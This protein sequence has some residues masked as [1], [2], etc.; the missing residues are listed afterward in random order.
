MGEMASTASV[1][2]WSEVIQSIQAVGDNWLLT[3]Q[4]ESGHTWVELIAAGVSIAQ[5]EGRQG[6][7][8]YVM[9]A[10]D[11]VERYGEPAYPGSSRTVG[12]VCRHLRV[13]RG[14]SICTPERIDFAYLG[15]KTLCDGP[16]FDASTLEIRGELI[17]HEN[18]HL[19]QFSGYFGTLV[20]RG[21]AS[22]D[23]SRGI[24][25]RQISL[26]GV[27]ELMAQMMNVGSPLDEDYKF[28]LTRPDA[29]G[30]LVLVS[31]SASTLEAWRHLQAE[32]GDSTG[33][34]VELASLLT[35]GLFG[36]AQAYRQLSEICSA[37]PHRLVP[38]R[39]R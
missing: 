29:N 2:N 39:W 7:S 19:A 16:R 33:L 4:D 9:L 32:C 25:W 17:E 26:I 30:Q 18:V 12:A 6:D 21:I 31:N 5:L 14:G 37:P 27:T 3:H 20:R 38:D 28:V 34:D 13:E 24:D 1:T 35:S 8:P 10:C 23:L 36:D 22:D 15:K 11:Q